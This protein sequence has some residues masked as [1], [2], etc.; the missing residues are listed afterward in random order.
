M[1]ASVFAAFA[2]PCFAANDDAD[3]IERVLSYVERY[4]ARAQTLVATETVTVQP[5]A[6]DMS[7]DGFARH[8]VN[9][10]R[11]EWDPANASEPL[12]VRQL[13]SSRGPSLG[14]PEQPDCLDP[15]SFSP[16]PLA[17]LLPAQRHKF[18]FQVGGTEV[19]AGIRTRRIEYRSVTREPPVVEWKGRCGMVR[20]AGPTRGRL[21]VDPA[22]GEILRFDEHLAGLV[23]LPGPPV[24]QVLDSPRSFTMERSDTTI[25][26]RKVAFADPEETLL[27]PSRI[28]SVTV[29]RNS[30][31]P[32]VRMTLTFT[33]YRRFLTGARIVP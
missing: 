16:E 6:R 1:F 27:L 7:K 22:S 19:V 17:F 9:E 30:G 12:A 4:Y 24:R 28:E 2:V 31:V 21:W 32:R 25:D 5:V 29:I 14:P 26:Y 18:Q 23:E 10:I 20:S 13:L 11:I 3:L 33:N 15:R 8:I